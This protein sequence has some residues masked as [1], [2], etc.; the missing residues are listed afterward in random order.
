[1]TNQI[2]G[3]CSILANKIFQSAIW[4][5]PPQYV[6]SFL[7]LVG[8]AAYKDG[9]IFKGHVLKRGELITTYGEIAGAL[10][11]TFN[12]AIITPSIKEIRIMLSWLQSEGM[13]LMKPLIDGT[14]ANKGRPTDLTRAYV[15]VL[16]SIVNYDIYQNLQNYKGRDKGR[17]S[18]EQ[19]QLGEIREKEKNR[20]RENALQILTYLNEKTG[21]RYRET[22]FIEARLKEGGT[23]EECKRIIDTKSK[24]SYF[25][26][27]PKYL[28]PQTL[29]RKSHWDVYVNESLPLPTGKTQQ[30]STLICPRCQRALVVK[31]D[32]YGKGCIHCERT[33]EVRA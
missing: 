31:N 16:I 32:L 2:P 5:K 28:N 4:R 12:R 15:G 13:I 9:Y 23:L 24:D 30:P 19:G 8:W 25:V 10:S 29:F 11:Y 17:P 7:R 14:S 20:Y 3:G 33:L 18:S 6:R 27:N 1:M 22:S 26:E 21:K